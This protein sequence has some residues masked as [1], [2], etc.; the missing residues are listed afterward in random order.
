MS[1]RFVAAGNLRLREFDDGVIVFDPLSLDAHLLNPAA[2]AI[3][4]LCID[5]A[6][7]SEEIEAFLADVLSSEDRPMAKIY[8]ERLLAELTALGLIRTD[9]SNAPV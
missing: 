4:E 1:A 9:E 5:K 7:R 6:A 2:A 8:A 3:L